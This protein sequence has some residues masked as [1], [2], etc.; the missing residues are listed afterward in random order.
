M[1]EGVAD[2]A[3][4]EGVPEKRGGG[5]RAGEGIGEEA[6]GCVKTALLA[7]LAQPGSNGELGIIIVLLSSGLRV[8]GRLLWLLL[9]LLMSEEDA[10]TAV[11]GMLGFLVRCGESGRQKRR[12]WWRSSSRRREKVGGAGNVVERQRGE[13][14]GPIRE[15]PRRPIFLLYFLIS[16]YPYIKSNRR[17]I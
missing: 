3:N 7:E 8:L 1:G 14:H 15:L 4:E 10:T 17:V 9:L 6:T 12:W 16:I 5:G 13:C 2:V 11:I